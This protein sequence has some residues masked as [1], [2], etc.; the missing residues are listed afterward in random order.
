[1]DPVI[2]AY[3]FCPHC[4]TALVRRQHGDHTRRVCPACGFVYYRNPLPAAGCLVDR[5][6]QV[7]LV[8]RKY[9]PQ[10]GYW[11]LPAGFME[12]DETPE[13]TAVR[14]T[15][16]ETGLRVDVQRLLGVFPWY[17][18]FLQGLAHEN[19]LLVVY[20]ATIIG[21]KLQ[22]GDDAQAAGWFSLDALPGQI[23]FASHEAALAA[24][25]ASKQMQ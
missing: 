5:E 2:N 24:W 9:A 18:D 14:E 6:G 17:D 1:M 16:E 4:A 15:E 3:R 11:S 10:A 21:G 23:A 22:A 7:L 8:Q 25:A 12:W 13:Q 20:E 19:G